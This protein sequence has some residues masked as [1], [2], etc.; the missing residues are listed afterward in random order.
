[1]GLGW[2]ITDRSTT[3]GDNDWV[4]KFCTRAAGL[5]ER[6][7]T[8]S[9]RVATITSLFSQGVPPEDVQNLGVYADAQ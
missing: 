8:S 6:L 9:F 4:I 3:A 5:P 1:M 2:L 7:S